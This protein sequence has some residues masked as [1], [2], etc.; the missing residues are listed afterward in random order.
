MKKI[1]LA[2]CFSLDFD[3]PLL[4]HFINYYISLGIKPENFLFVLNVFVDNRNLKKGLDI[5]SEYNIFPKDIWCYEYESE[6]KW[7]RIH[8][9]LN[10]HVLSEDWVI[11]P[12]SDEFFQFPM[13]LNTLT[14]AMDNQNL[15]AAQA[16]LVDRLSSDGKIKNIEDDVDLFSQFP[17][18][19]NLANLIGIAGVK[20]AMYKGYLRANN[21]SGQIHQ[22]C[23]SNTRYTHGGNQSLHQTDLG[24]KIMGDYSEKRKY[25]P[26]NFNESVYQVICMQHGFIAHHFKWHGTV[27]EK[28]KQR[29][30]TYTKFRRPQL[31]QSERLL[32]FYKSNDDSFLIKDKKG[33]HA[34]E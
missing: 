5:L 34:D 30:E 8:M 27:L 31:I 19:A 7:Q 11:H 9:I 18:K 21:G 10:K 12:D 28:L 22:Q 32:N 2:C 15:N 17:Q 25:D 33:E 26:E 20:L 1:Y 16:F 4:R 29:V 13:D 6:E 3:L 24:K 23:L 14:A